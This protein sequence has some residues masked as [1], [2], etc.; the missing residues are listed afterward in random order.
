[1]KE[2]LF[3]KL[4]AYI[5]LLLS[6]TMFVLWCCNSG[7]FKAVNLDSFVGVIVALLAIIV[8]IVLGWQIYNAID[9]RQKIK[10]LDIIKIQF[11]NQQNKIEEL[12]IQTIHRLNLT[13]GDISTSQREYQTAFRYYIIALNHSLLL[14][15]PLNIDVIQSAMSFV[16]SQLQKGNK[17]DEK[18]YL[19]V[20]N[21]DK[22]IK[23]LT[24]Y[25]LI[26]NWY[27]PLYKKFIDNVNK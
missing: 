5:A 13:W 9:L 16:A 18:S 26:K 2:G 27:E 25:Q 14:N 4:C 23:R 20:L 15:E 8:T 24:K 19:D 17:L 3:S 1:M 6:I 11:N 22:A 10:E 12:S 7:G 21:T